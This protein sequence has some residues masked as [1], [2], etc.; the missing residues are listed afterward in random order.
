MPRAGGARQSGVPGDDEASRIDAGVAGA[1]LATR[2]RQSGS[3]SQAPPVRLRQ[4]GSYS[5]SHIHTPPVRLISMP[6]SQAQPG[7][8]QADRQAGG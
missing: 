3:A 4:S 5:A 6:A 7:R 2:L 1:A 8:G